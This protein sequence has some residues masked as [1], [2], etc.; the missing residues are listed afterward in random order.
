MEGE[1]E[2]GIVVFRFESLESTQ[3]EARRRLTFDLDLPP[4]V[5]RAERQLGGIGRSGRR[6]HS[7]E[8]GLWFTHVYPLSRPLGDYTGISLVAGVAVAEAIQDTLHTFCQ[9]KW[10]NDLLLS[11]RKVAGI[12]CE[13]VASAG[14]NAL[15][16]GIGINVNFVSADLGGDLRVPAIT[17]SDF[18]HRDVDIEALF[19]RILSE[20]MGALDAFEE[21]G[22][23]PFL[24]LLIERLAWIDRPVRFWLDDGSPLV[25]GTL[26]GVDDDGR[27]VVEVGGRLETYNAGELRLLDHDHDAGVQGVGV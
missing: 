13:T 10:P 24:P 17:L 26:R 23:R 22:L 3:L 21:S 4:F 14:G 9:I 1:D 18:M 12:L 5:V 15:L 25:N 19:A 2:H 6:W 7:P 27:L 8:G 16:T 11:D 20:Y